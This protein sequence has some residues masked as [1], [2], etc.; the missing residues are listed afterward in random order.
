MQATF[1]YGDSRS[2]SALQLEKLKIEKRKNDN[3]F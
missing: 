2:S 1:L 3:D